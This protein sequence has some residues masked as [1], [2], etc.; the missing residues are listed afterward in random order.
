METIMKNLA[1]F[2]ISGLFG[3]SLAG[4]EK[5]FNEEESITVQ[6]LRDHMFYLASDELE[7][8][9]TGTPGYDKAVQ[10]AATQ[11]RQAGLLPICRIDDS[12]FS[13][14]QDFSLE[15]FTPDLNSTINIQKASESQVFKFEENYIMLYGGPFDIK[16][17]KGGLAFVGS[18]IREPDFGID[19]YK[20]VNVRG[21]WAVII[22]TI[23]DNV[24][25]KLPEPI[26]KKYLYR[27][28]NDRLRTQYA[29]DA[30]AIGLLQIS[31]PS[32]INGWIR[33]AQAYRDFY[34]FPGIG[35]PWFNSELPALRIDS[36]MVDYLFSGQKYNPTDQKKQSKSFVLDNCELALRK[37][38]HYSNVN[39][40]NAIGL[41][42]GADPVLKNEYIIVTAHLDHMGIEDG[43]VMNGANDN[44]SGSSAVLE[45]AEALAKSKPLRS[46]ICILCAGEEEGLLGSYYFTENPL[47]PIEKIIADINIDMI[48][49]SNTD[50]K[51]IA[52]IGANRINPELKEIIS[53]TGERINYIN[54]NWAYADTCRFINSSD[55]YPFYMKKIPSVFFFSGGNSDTHSPTDDAE[56]IDYEFFQRS[57]SFIYEVIIDL[58]NSPKE[59]SHSEG[60]NRPRNL[61][62]D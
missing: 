29:K 34:T 28:D 6:E 45:I 10:Y 40:A 21:K 3:M 53:K 55:H 58:A 52:P 17:V 56:K 2:L 9:L 4:Q 38:F 23:P 18:G 54:V 37:E 22:E 15:K 1:I 20:N 47:V 26:L 46:I 13:Y 19:D 49:C 32:N 57:C 31:G 25:K 42:E 51:G 44:A 24:K 61:A 62:I 35:Q 8:R 50:V 36:L 27:P 60:E 33:M 43:K 48:G 7:G 11:L 14:Y 39:S 12:T 59:T 30:G 5:T 41:I 16:E